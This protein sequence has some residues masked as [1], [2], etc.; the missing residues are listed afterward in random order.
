MY[1]GGSGGLASLGLDPS[2]ATI[3]AALGAGALATVAVAPFEKA[4]VRLQKSTEGEE[5]EGG[6]FSVLESLAR[7]EAGPLVGLFNGVPLLLPKDI[8]F[9]VVKVSAAGHCLSS[10]RVPA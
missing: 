9:A 3:A 10:S 7:D 1:A 8:V 2:A 5:S 4:R 6:V